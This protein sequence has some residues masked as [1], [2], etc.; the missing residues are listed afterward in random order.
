MCSP[1]T[2]QNKAV[3]MTDLAEGPTRV[4]VK[5]ALAHWN[6][7]LQRI[8]SP[9]LRYGFSVV[10]VAI[11]LGLAL[12]LQYYNFREVELPALTLAVALV[13]WS[14]GVGPSR[15]AVVLATC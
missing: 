5:R 4:G 13:A 6:R 15:L 11:V 1:P 2:N 10:C 7:E 14:A 3:A 8:H 9:I 12:A